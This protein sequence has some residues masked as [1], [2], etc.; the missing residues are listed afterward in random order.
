MQKCGTSESCYGCYFRPTDIDQYNDDRLP[1]I[2]G[3]VA[4]QFS[5]HDPSV[6]EDETISMTAASALG[7]NSVSQ[8]L[9]DGIRTAA[10]MR[11]S[12]E[13]NLAK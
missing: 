13:C 7:W 12:A 9:V 8:H 5:Y 3:A 6:L 11:R 10:V 4:E 2:L 1:H